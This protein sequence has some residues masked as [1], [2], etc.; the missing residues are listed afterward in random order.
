MGE[1]Q[2]TLADFAARSRFLLKAAIPPSR[3]DLITLAHNVGTIYEEEFD[4]DGTAHIIF[5]IE[6]KY[7]HRFKE[8]MQ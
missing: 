8:F 5:A 6:E 1:L 4:D 3:Y 7:Q 2:C